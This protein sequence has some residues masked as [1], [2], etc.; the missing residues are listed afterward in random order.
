[1]AP[2]LYILIKMD[3]RGEEEAEREE[4]VSLV[5][6]SCAAVAEWANT[7]KAGRS[8]S[9]IV[10]KERASSD[11]FQIRAE[12]K[13]KRPEGETSLHSS[14]HYILYNRRARERGV[15]VIEHGGNLED[16]EASSPL[17]NKCDRPK[18]SRTTYIDSTHSKY[19]I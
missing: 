10:A 3:E 19:Y 7:S 18:S 5:S 1:M 9:I 12:W 8:I 17:V 16:E 2:S 6:S 4:K 13:G 11:L 15:R 14:T